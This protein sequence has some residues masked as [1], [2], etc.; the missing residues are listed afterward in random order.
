MFTWK[1][2]GR[3]LESIIGYFLVTAGMRRD[4][5][6][7]T[8]ICGADIGSDHHLVLIKMKVR[9]RKLRWKRRAN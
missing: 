2:P 6:D 4:K 8:L 1:H 7:V 3:G 5:N 9:A